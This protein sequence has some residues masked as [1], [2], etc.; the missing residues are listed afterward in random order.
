[1]AA[2]GKKVVAHD[3]AGACPV[4]AGAPELPAGLR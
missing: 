4:P 1:V 3:A 2:A